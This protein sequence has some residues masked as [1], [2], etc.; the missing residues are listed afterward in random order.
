MSFLQEL[1][2]VTIAQI[3]FN[4]VI[5]ILSILRTTSSHTIFNTRNRAA[6]AYRACCSRC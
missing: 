1:K 4:Q 3:P 6:T 5:P 2:K